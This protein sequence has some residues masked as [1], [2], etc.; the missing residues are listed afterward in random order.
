[1]LNSWTLHIG[2]DWTELPCPLAVSKSGRSLQTSSR[3]S[4]SVDLQQ[5]TYRECETYMG[6]LGQL[7][8]T[9]NFN[10]ILLPEF[11]NCQVNLHL[12]QRRHGGRPLWYCVPHIWL[13]PTHGI[14][15]KIYWTLTL[16][17]LPNSSLSAEQSFC[18][19]P[20]QNLDIDYS[21]TG[22]DIDK[23]FHR[24]IIHLTQNWFGNFLS[25][26]HSHKVLVAIDLCTI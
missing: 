6:R 12:E 8:H 2:V 20:F 5:F 24:K 1:M 9:V 22:I 26:I 21:H 4:H 15:Q 23:N 16:T 18:I 14:H 3:P 25:C 11:R 10:P 17:N 7:N 19:L 13:R